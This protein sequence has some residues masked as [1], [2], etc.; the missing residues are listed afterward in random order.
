MREKQTGAPTRGGFDSSVK[1]RFAKSF[2]HDF[3]GSS[4]RKGKQLLAGR[5]MVPFRLR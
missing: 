5:M 2:L 1:I 4:T 3:S